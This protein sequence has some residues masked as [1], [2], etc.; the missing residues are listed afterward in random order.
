MRMET[1]KVS[2]ASLENKTHDFLLM[3][4]VVAL[5][6]L[7]IAFEWSTTEVKKY[8]PVVETNW[9]DV[10]VM[11][12]VTIQKPLTP[13]PP[14]VAAPPKIMLPTNISTVNNNVAT[15]D[16]DFVAPDVDE[17]VEPIVTPIEEPIDEPDFFLVSEKAPSFPGGQKAMMDYLRDHIKY[18]AAL[19]EAGI[20]GRVIVSFVVDTDGSIK[21]IT[22][23]RS[24]HERLDAE[25][26]RVVSS[27]P[28]WN[29][30]ENQGRKVRV[31]YQLPVFFRTLN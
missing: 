13:P 12:P 14:A 30:G 20:Q 7:F 27:M 2:S 11:L 3:G 19:R 17:P 10:D 18:P 31:R 6:F 15:P 8:E 9:G 16:V 25:A 4:L 21:D 24:A 23:L 1:K 22:V 28:N 26:I 5:G 29:P